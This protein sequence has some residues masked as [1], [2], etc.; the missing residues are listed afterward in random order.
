MYAKDVWNGRSAKNR[1]R[2]PRVVVSFVSD[3]Q[4]SNTTY[5]LKRGARS[6]IKEQPGAA[7]ARG[8]KK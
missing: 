6:R 4:V 5:V 3:Q 2:E 8:R 1:P 7:D